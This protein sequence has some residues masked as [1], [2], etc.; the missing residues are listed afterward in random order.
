MYRAGLESL[1]GLRRRGDTF[2][3][4]PCIPSTWS[5]YEIVWRFGNTRYNISVANPEHQCRGVVLAT[6]DGIGAN[7]D[8]IPLVDDGRTHDVGIV[9]GPAAENS[10]RPK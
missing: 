8:A 2:T 10:S 7:Y 1:L 5:G 9:L 3:V 4:N 6:L